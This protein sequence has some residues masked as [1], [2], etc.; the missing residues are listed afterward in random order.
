MTK[1]R[2]SK[3]D[4]FFRAQMANPKVAQEFF[5]INLPAF[6][7]KDVDLSTLNLKNDSFIGD[8]LRQK[9][10]DLLFEVEIKTK[11]G[12]NEKG[13]FYCLCEHQST[14]QKLMPF[15]MLQYMISIQQKHMEDHNTSTLPFV[16][17]MLVY[18]GKAKYTYSMDLFSL[19]GD[20]EDMARK[21]WTSPYSLIDL[22]QIPDEELEPYLYFGATAFLMKHIRD[23]DAMTFLS[24]VLDALAKIEKSGDSGY[25]KR[26][27]TYLIEA[28]NIEDDKDFIRLVT[29]KLSLKEDD[30][31]TL[32][33]K[34]TQ[35]A[36]KQGMRQ[37]VKHV[38]LGMF[39][40]RMTIDKIS[41][42]TGLTID[43]LEEI[44][45]KDLN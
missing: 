3:H 17:P 31:M 26:S 5:E 21:V 29:N 4:R 19:F 9:V 35:E 44:K 30:I 32:A 12:K 15:R 18:A 33:E 24:K 14:P 27:I 2:L 11:K 22:T 43:Q 6:I 7:K 34:W 39:E 1:K 28:G 40:E 37:G 41:K 23:Q 13:Y 45:P 25:I 10:A 42:I 8:D 36:L 38:A 20:H 16:F